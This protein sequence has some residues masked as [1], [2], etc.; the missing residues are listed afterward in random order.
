MS[1]R[2]FLAK[3]INLG[4]GKAVFKT[5]ALKADGT[6]GELE[7]DPEEEILEFQLALES[8]NDIDNN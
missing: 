7:T 5:V 1:D 4:K 8:D 3:K 2:T 6:F